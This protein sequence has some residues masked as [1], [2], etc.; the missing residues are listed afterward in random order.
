[1]NFRGSNQDLRQIVSVKLGPVLRLSNQVAALWGTAMAHA[2]EA[3]S[4]AGGTRPRSWLVFKV[5]LIS[6]AAL[7]AL[8]QIP[9]L[10]P[11]R[12]DGRPLAVAMTVAWCAGLLVLALGVIRRHRSRFN[13]RSLALLI[14][15]IAVYLA[16]CRT[17][18]PI[19]PTGLLAYALSVVMLCEAHR[20]S[21]DD[22]FG[23]LPFRGRL[24]RAIMVVGGVIFLAIFSLVLGIQTLIQCG[25]LRW[26][27]SH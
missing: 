6:V 14:A 23:R 26:T 19:I 7:I 3:S 10:D 2:E 1:M 21:V 8:M 15:F 22:R 24:S 4:V 25:V 17:V 11:G 9:R 20:A 16:L 18:H 27:L 12:I 5:Y 13:L